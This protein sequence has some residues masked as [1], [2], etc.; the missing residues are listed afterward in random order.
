MGI[1]CSDHVT[2]LYPQ[3]L[4]LTSPTGG[5]RFVGIVRSRTKATEFYMLDWKGKYNIYTM[6]NTTR[7]TSKRGQVIRTSQKTWK[8]GIA[9]TLD[10]PRSE[11]VVYF[12][13]FSGYDG[14]VKNLY[15]IGLFPHS[16]L[17]LLWSTRR[18]IAAP[19]VEVLCFIFNDWGPKIQGGK[20]PNGWMTMPTYPPFE[21]M[22]NWMNK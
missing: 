9:N 7:R 17:T 5:G 6:K 14:L 18:D 8:H 11:A 21:W 13:L 3:K 12:C 16:D 15:H 10:W 2:P 20:R 19:F 4:A 1:R 22:D